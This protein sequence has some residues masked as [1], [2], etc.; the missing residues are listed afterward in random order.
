MMEMKQIVQ[1]KIKDKQKIIKRAEERGKTID[2]NSM[3]TVIY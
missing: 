1:M 3:M 2:R